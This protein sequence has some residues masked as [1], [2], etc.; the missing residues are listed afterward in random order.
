MRGV[1]QTTRTVVDLLGLTED[2]IEAAIDLAT[3]EVLD[4]GS[5]WHTIGRLT[6]QAN[7]GWQVVF[8]TT[9]T[10]RAMDWTVRVEPPQTLEA[11]VSPEDSVNTGKN[12]QTDY[13]KAET[14]QALRAMER[15]QQA[16]PDAE[17]TGSASGA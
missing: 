11:L 12:Y 10:P 3:E 14:R 4:S 13:D 17:E 1:L 9:D 16:A 15:V 2:E 8:E 6:F 7:N 5:G